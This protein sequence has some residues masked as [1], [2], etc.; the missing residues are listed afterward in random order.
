MSAVRVQDA[1]ALHTWETAMVTF[2]INFR[3][4]KQLVFTGSIPR[5]RGAT[6]EPR[7]PAGTGCRLQGQSWLPRV[8]V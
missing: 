3:G 5:Q 2:K 8:Q 1:T 6:P 4:R 7:E